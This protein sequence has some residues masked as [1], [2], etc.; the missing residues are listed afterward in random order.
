MVNN[1]IVSSAQLYRL[2]NKTLAPGKPRAALSV[3]LRSSVNP[4]PPMG[5]RKKRL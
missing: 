2:A 1:S 3:S 5:K 4:E